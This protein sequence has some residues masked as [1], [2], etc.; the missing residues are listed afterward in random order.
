[1]D[2]FD[3]VPERLQPPAKLEGFLAALGRQQG[4]DPTQAFQDIGQPE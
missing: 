2:G 3:L 4:H 1:V